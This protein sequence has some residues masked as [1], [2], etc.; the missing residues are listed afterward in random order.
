MTPRTSVH[1]VASGTPVAPRRRPRPV[2][3][4]APVV[5]ASG[6]RLRR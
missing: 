6:V 2:A 1:G 5:E 4:W 3:F